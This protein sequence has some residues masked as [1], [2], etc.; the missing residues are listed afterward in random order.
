MSAA[1]T[2]R[3]SMSPADIVRAILMDFGFAGL[4][5]KFEEYCGK[6]VTRALMWALVFAAFALTLRIGVESLATVSSMI[7]GGKGDWWSIADDILILAVATACLC[8]I[9]SVAVTKYGKRKT[10]MELAGLVSDARDLHEHTGQL[11]ADW[12]RKD[13]ESA[14]RFDELEQN[15]YEAEREVKKRILE[16]AKRQGIFPKND[17]RKP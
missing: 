17:A 9:V 7:A 13:R 3:A 8:A 15:L 5:E 1:T 2:R 4:I 12:E 14:R 16:E 10:R 6:H 11:L